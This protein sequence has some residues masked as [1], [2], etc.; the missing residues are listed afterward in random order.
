MIY[1]ELN[2]SNANEDG[3]SSDESFKTPEQNTERER[4]ERLESLLNPNIENSSLLYQKIDEYVYNR[5][6]AITEKEK[7]AK[8][9]GYGAKD[10][11]QM[12]QRGEDIRMQLHELEE[13][14]IGNGGDGKSFLKLLGSIG[15]QAKLFQG[16]VV[17]KT[18]EGNIHHTDLSIGLA[19]SLV[20]QIRRIN[21][22]VAQPEINERIVKSTFE[23][24]FMAPLSDERFK[25]M[26]DM[27][28]EKVSGAVAEILDKISDKKIK[29]R[30]QVAWNVL[31]SEF[32]T[33]YYNAEASQVPETQKQ[34]THDKIEE[35]Q[36]LAEQREKE[37]VEQL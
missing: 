25:K 9:H 15:E 37:R 4:K 16:L 6:V 17:S 27:G 36:K 26:L 2:H 7:A 5:E 11:K 14:D 34:L 20:N 31:E 3:D 23:E 13:R 19:E 32:L 33:R 22:V 1:S 10:I 29:E 28:E 35:P 18:T 24:E 12:E 21:H 30:Y 8:K